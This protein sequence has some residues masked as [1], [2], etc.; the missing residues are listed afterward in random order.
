[1]VGRQQIVD[2]NGTDQRRLWVEPIP[3]LDVSQCAYMAGL[4]D[5]EGCVEAGVYKSHGTRCLRIALTIITADRGAEY[6]AEAFG[7]KFHDR[8]SQRGHKNAKRVAISN[9]KRIAEIG[10]TLLPFLRIKKWQMSLALYAIQ[11][12]SRSKRE[13]AVQ[14]IISLK[15]RAPYG[16]A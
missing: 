4:F 2:L 5:G 12:P 14:A 11:T 3:E 7:E 16:V 1:M 10:Y 8:E 13:R 15:R 9:M 6:F